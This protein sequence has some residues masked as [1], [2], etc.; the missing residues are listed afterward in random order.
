MFLHTDDVPARLIN[1][2]NSSAV[3]FAQEISNNLCLF[4][5]HN[6]TLTTVVSL[7]KVCAYASMNGVRKKKN[8]LQ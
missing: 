8:S 6:F 7:K 5:M 4:I 3:R 1:M 2:A